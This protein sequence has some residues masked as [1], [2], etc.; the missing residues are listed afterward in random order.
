MIYCGIDWAESHHDVAVINDA[1]EL[2]AKRRITDDAEGYRILA[3]LLADH[4][5]DPDDRIPVCI[6][7]NRGLLVALLN[8]GGRKVYAINPMAASRYRDRHGV[9]RKKSDPGDALILA[10]ILRTDMHV[11]R[12][13]PA[14]T[15]QAR[16][17]AVLARAQQ[18]A[19]WN[20]QQMSNQVRSLL[21]EYYPAALDA[22]ATW[23]NPLTRPEAR[24]ILRIAPTPA[25]GAELTIAQLRAAL[26]RAGRSRGIKATAER[27]QDVLRGEYA[28]QPPEV[29]DAMGAQLLG[30]PRQLDAACIAADELAAQDETAFREHPDSKIMLSFPGIG[31]QLGARILAEIGDDR[32]RFS[33]ARALK[34]YVGSAPITRAS[35]KK[36]HVGRRMVKNDRLNHA[37]YLWSFAALNASEGANAHYR[38]RRERGDW[39]AAGLRHLFNRMI[40]RLFHCLQRREVFEEHE[41][42]PSAL[43]D[44]A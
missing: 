16:A 41:A 9:S 44:A 18:D 20:R 39:H 19:Q 11:H 25:K 12:P 4:G 6:E 2:P 28:H 37:G 32:S 21:R 24:E 26:A 30:L 13:I 23:T 36:H 22:F 14:D 7:T 29:E 43:R 33:D 5:D 17:V 15:P 10:N 27:I 31:P 42:F 34:A 38:A 1:G 3:D 35:G 8:Q 40:G